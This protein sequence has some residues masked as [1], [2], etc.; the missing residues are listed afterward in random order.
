M[1]SQS[2]KERR[3]YERFPFREDILID[4]TRLCTSMDISEGGLYVSSIQAFEENSIIDVTIPFKGEK[5]TFKA[6]IQY[7]QHGIG[8]GIMFINL[9]DEQK[10]RLKELIES[11][12][13]K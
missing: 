8:M 4:G 9:T 6:K 11:I 7:C 12:A 3:K 13:E 10:S 5:L 2:G 1:D